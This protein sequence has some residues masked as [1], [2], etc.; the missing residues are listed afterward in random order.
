M[1]DDL[2]SRLRAAL[3]QADL[4]RA[5]ES[6]RVYLARLREEPSTSGRRLQSRLWLLLPATAIL[7]GVIAFTGGSSQPLPGPTPSPVAI[8]SPSVA[9]LPASVD[10]L[11][12]QT[13]SELIAN[14]AAGRARGGPYALSGY[15]TNRNFGHSCAAPR[16]QPGDLELYCSDGEWGITERDEEILNV[17]FQSG[18]AIPAAGPHL[19][20]W[21]PSRADQERLFGWIEIGPSASPVPLQAWRPVPIVV[22]GHFDDPAAAACRPEALQICR[23]RFVIDRIVAFDPKSVPAPTPSPTPTPFPFSNPPPDLFPNRECYDGVP[24]SF[25]GWT[26]TNKLNIQFDRQGYV[27]AMVTRDVIPIGDWYDNPNYPGHKSR[28]WAR[29]VCLSQEAGIMEF[30]SVNGTSFLEL[31]DGRRIPG[32][33]P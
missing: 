3:G 17:N 24:K 11:D 26:T 7:A 25:T 33:A 5:P 13:V 18:R 8:A 22:V 6:T 32:Q 1:N 21:V 4:P 9:S 27:Y 29:G 30:G 14:R 10:G 16:G 31:D 2:A 19:T 20:P 12:V 15:W 28:W 23:D